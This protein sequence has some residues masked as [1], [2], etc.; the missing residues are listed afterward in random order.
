[1]GESTVYNG[2]EIS[3]GQILPPYAEPDRIY[4]DLGRTAR[5][6]RVGRLESVNIMPFSQR[7]EVI[8]PDISGFHD[9]SNETTAS[10]AGTASKT[11]T[12]RSLSNIREDDIDSFARVNATIQINTAH[13]DIENKSARDPIVWAH[14][15]DLGL[16]EGLRNASRK[17]M[18]NNRDFFDYT[19]GGMW[20]ALLTKD[21]TQFYT[22]GQINNDNVQN[23]AT[24]LAYVGITELLI[25]TIR[26]QRNGGKFDPEWTLIPCLP[27]DRVAAVQVMSRTQKLVKAK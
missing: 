14:G 24:T 15:I 23:L 8:S 4:L 16:R 22:D 6:A 3:C 5:I 10:A 27:L 1:M 25:T 17:H 7:E 26:K 9:Y 19:I 13:P 12:R 11:K 20:A 18:V 21:I 2:V